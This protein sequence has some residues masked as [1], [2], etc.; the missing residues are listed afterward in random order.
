MI[1]RIAG[2]LLCLALVASLPA[3]AT[4]QEERD[5]EDS[6]RRRGGEGYYGGGTIHSNSYPGTYGRY[7]RGP[8]GRPGRRY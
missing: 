5:A 7:G 6:W 3:C 2:A 8:Y 1:R 4:S